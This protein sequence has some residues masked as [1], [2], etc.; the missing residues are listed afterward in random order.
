MRRRDLDE[1]GAATPR[2]KGSLNG[3]IVLD[4][5]HLPQGKYSF[6]IYTLSSRIEHLLLTTGKTLRWWKSVRH[7]VCPTQCYY[8]LFKTEI[9]WWMRTSFCCSPEV[10]YVFLYNSRT[11]QEHV[12]DFVHSR[13][14]QTG[15]SSHTVQEVVKA[16]E[17]GLELTA[18][19]AMGN[20][21]SNKL[22]YTFAPTRSV[23]NPNAT[24]KPTKTVNSASFFTFSTSN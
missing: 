24:V 14:A 10:I 6:S 4:A 5:C 7:I 20:R 1:I 2:T 23:P 13:C 15:I 12:S 16:I 18:L 11:D 8:L 19:K 9:W 3:Y 22:A 17:L 21:R